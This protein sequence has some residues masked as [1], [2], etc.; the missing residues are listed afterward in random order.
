MADRTGDRYQKW[1]E[2]RLLSAILTQLEDWYHSAIVS[3]VATALIAQ[4]QGL[5]SNTEF[6]Y[7]RVDPSTHTLQTIEYEHHEIHGGSHYFIIDASE[8]AINEVFDLTFQTPNT[9]KWT[10]WIFTLDVTGETEWFIYEG[11]TATNPLAGAVTP[12]NNNRNSANTSGNTLRAELQASLA[13]A[14][15]DTAVGGATEIAHGVLGANKQ[16][17]NVDRGAEI[18]LKQNTLYCMRAIAN[19]ATIVA[20]KM[21]WYEHT[22]KD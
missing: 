8:L 6:A 4:M 22:D 7:L 15:A 19:A 18:V 16:G 12:R 5:I 20:F 11:A 1:G 13:A 3:P 17:G 21:E 2:S 10:H 14:N 9:T